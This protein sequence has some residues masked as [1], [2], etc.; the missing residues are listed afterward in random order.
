GSA[1]AGS[2]L[3][4][5]PGYERGEA[6]LARLGQ[7]GLGGPSLPGG[8]RLEVQ[9]AGTIDREI[10]GVTRGLGDDQAP[11]GP[12]GTL[13]RGEQSSLPGPVADFV[14]GERDEDRVERA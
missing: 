9:R 10:R 3:E 12:Q 7:P 1:P 2:P 6:Q 11:A 13:Q 8:E 14:S 4:H 5:D